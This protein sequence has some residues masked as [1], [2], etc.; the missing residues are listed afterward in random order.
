MAAAAEGEGST[1][2]EKRDNKDCVPY[3]G[4]DSLLSYPGR[5]GS[6]CFSLLQSEAVSAV[7]PHIKLFFLF[8]FQ[9]YYYE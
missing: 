8:F 5:S 4:G 6:N 2:R 1:E 9:F 7:L 3:E